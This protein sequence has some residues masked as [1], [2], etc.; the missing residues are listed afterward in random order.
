MEMMQHSTD[1]DV[2]FDQISGDY[3]VW[4]RAV[5]E[6]AP[7]LGD[8]EVQERALRSVLA[9]F[10]YDL[11]IETLGYIKTRLA[12]AKR[13]ALEARA[14]TLTMRERAR[15]VRARAADLPEVRGGRTFRDRAG[16]VWGVRE[17]AT[18]SPWRRA[19][20]CLVFSSEMAVRRVWTLPADWRS[21]TDAELE[22]LSW[23][24]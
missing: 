4:E 24:M 20:H 2:V 10:R 19:E 9:Q 1:P 6:A 17:V 18:A 14:E 5:R 16:Q 21:L 8:A 11:P 23:T 13:E 7:E 12:R 15:A 3:P 22:R